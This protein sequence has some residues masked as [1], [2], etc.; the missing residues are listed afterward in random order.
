MKKLLIGIL[1]SIGSFLIIANN[2]N[3]SADEVSDYIE[4]YP[5][6]AKE[7]MDPNSNWRGT[8]VGHSNWTF[9]YGDYRYWSV[10]GSVRYTKDFIDK[11][12][13]GAITAD[14][15]STL[16]FNAFASIIMND[17]ESEYTFATT[18]ARTDLTSVVHRIYTFYDEYGVLYRFEDHIN[19]YWI[20]NEGSV[21]TVDVTNAEG[22]VST[23]NVHETQDWRL[24]TDAEIAAF[25]EP[26]AVIPNN[27]LLSHIRI[28][29][30]EESS[31]G[32]ILEPMGY[33]KWTNT[34]YGQE[35]YPTLEKSIIVEGNPDNFT[36][37]PGGVVI[38]YGTVDR[39]GTN[40]KTLEFIK[41]QPYMMLDSNNKM[42]KEYENQAPSF[43]TSL[44]ILDSD[45]T[46]EGINHVVEYKETFSINSLVE[47]TV[48]DYIHMFD[49]E[50]RIIAE[51][52]KI[53]YTIKISLDEKV[54]DEIKVNYNEESDTYTAEKETTVI[55]TSIFGRAYIVTFE[56]V[57]PVNEQLVES[58]SIDLVVGKLP[59]KF[60]GVKANVYYN[61]NTSFDILDGIT[62]NDSYGGDLTNVIK[63]ITPLGLN[64]YNPLPGTY[65][66]EF[67]VSKDYTFY[68]QPAVVKVEIQ[69]NDETEIKE[70]EYEGIDVEHASSNAANVHVYTK[71]G[72]DKVVKN[73]AT[74][75]WTSEL[76]II[77][78]G[79][80]VMAFSRGNNKVMDAENP[81]ATKDELNTNLKDANFYK[82]ITLTENQTAIVVTGSASVPLN[83]VAKAIVYGQNV[84]VQEYV[85]DVTHTVTTRV[86][87]NIIIDDKTAPS[88]LLKEKDLKI[89]GT[90]YTSV[91]EAIL[92]NVLGIDNYSDVA[93]VVA[94]NGGMDLSKPGVYT[95]KVVG[96][97]VAGNT[98]EITFSIEVLEKDIAEANLID[99]ITK[100]L[101]NKA[102][103]PIWMVFVVAFV[104]AGL[105]FGGAVLFLKKKQ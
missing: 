91:N 19:Q 104:A 39:D 94:S 13:D 87:Q 1:L 28:S 68:G 41:S 52:K 12:S 82:T 67:E 26:N 23:K 58:V 95:V 48:V 71:D 3:V 21:K 5:Y 9:T 31:K 70:F 63:V 25:S 44:T 84:S 92:S 88:L 35:D 47:N 76:V 101:G 102:G 6:D 40:K 100:N 64:K 22:A 81:H 50:E 20:V 74:M 54:V 16:P 30:D 83:G 34:F 93:L 36:V 78:D 98:S 42:E 57:S 99:Q 86:S 96:E 65:K 32:Y 73:W 105:S 33:L 77:E 4:L 51:T 61:E 72:Y 29:I 18:N 2:F 69:N 75:S 37:M 66:V 62:A 17:T 59:P 8:K 46:I 49:D 89:V 38:S 10:N 79:K 45:K 97:D 60:E 11:N 53:G 27:A 103:A 43:G 80:A 90:K 55:D 7:S 56:A 24:A 15:M 14:E 85:A